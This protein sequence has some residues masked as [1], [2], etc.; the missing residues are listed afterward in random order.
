MAAAKKPKKNREDSAREV[1]AMLLSEWGTKYGGSVLGA[2]L[3]RTAIAPILKEKGLVDGINMLSNA[4]QVAFGGNDTTRSAIRGAF[5]GLAESVKDLDGFPDDDRNAQR[6]WAE[7]K[8]DVAF[9]KLK[10]LLGGGGSESQ[11]R[12]FLEA[13]A[14]LGEEEQEA[15]RGALE[16]IRRE[17]DTITDVAAQEKAKREFLAA[18]STV[19]LSVESLRGV[20]S[21]GSDAA[22]RAELLKERFRPQK[23]AADKVEAEA[24][25]WGKRLAAAVETPQA[26]AVVKRVEDFSGNREAGA[27]LLR[28]AARGPKPS[29][30][31]APKVGKFA[32]WFRDPKR[33]WNH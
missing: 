33:F 14:K 32:S 10:G 15:I 4:A 31:T 3:A 11:E 24:V 1:V 25:R 16:L 19:K 26:K 9:T 12:P 13:L 5:E 7:G 30:P 21:A 28:H 23:S 27:D 8:V 2:L 20:V 22:A 29:A 6:A 17:I 18:Y